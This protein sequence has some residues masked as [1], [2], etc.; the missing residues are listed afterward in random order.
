MNSIWLFLFLG[1]TGSAGPAHFG[2]RVLAYRHH[3]DKKYE[4]KKGTE[5]GNLAYS[6]W[7]MGFGFTK[8]KDSGMNLFAGNAGVMGWLALIGIIGTTVAIT[9]K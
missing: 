3:L 8:F 6:W 1:L 7:L 5:E 9:L 2:F 4:F